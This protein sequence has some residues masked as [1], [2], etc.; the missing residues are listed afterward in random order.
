MAW[1][2]AAGI[3]VGIGAEGLLLGYLADLLLK[4]WHPERP[5]DPFD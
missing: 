5:G 2:L 3:I 1:L 4:R